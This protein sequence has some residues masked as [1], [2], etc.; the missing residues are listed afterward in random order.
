MSENKK[1][2]SGINLI[3]GIVALVCLAMMFVPMGEA[4]GNFNSG[5]ST[6]GAMPYIWSEATSGLRS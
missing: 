2:H 1:H 6:V 5:W 4:R 3:C